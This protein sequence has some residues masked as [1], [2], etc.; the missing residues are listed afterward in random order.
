[1]VRVS[2][3]YLYGLCRFPVNEASKL[4]HIKVQDQ[5]MFSNFLPDRYYLTD[6]W[7]EIVYVALSVCAEALR[8]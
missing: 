1:M 5:L 7:K 8:T 4:N 3:H 2:G 6:L